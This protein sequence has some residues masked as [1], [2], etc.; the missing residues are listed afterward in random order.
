MVMGIFI[1]LSLKAN[2]NVITWTKSVNRKGEI[3]SLEKNRDNI[4][5]LPLEGQPAG[6]SR[7]D[8]SLDLAAPSSFLKIKEI[9]FC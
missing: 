6:G 2:S 3:A 5:I 1:L 4:F 7:E 8:A 9:V